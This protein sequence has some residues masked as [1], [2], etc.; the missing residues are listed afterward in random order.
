MRPRPGTAADEV[1]AE[2]VKMGLAARKSADELKA[3]LEAEVVAAEE[4]GGVKSE[5]R[6]V[7]DAEEARRKEVEAG[8]ARRKEVETERQQA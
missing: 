2:T 6:R 3:A 4:R 7:K 1:S 8:E 5:A